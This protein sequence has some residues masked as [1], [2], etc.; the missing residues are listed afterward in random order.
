MAFF[1]HSHG[2]QINGGNFYNVAGSMNVQQQ[3]P[4]AAWG[5]QEYL[6]DLLGPGSAESSRAHG[7]G[8]IPHPS[9]HGVQRSILAAGSTRYEP[10]S[11]SR[12]RQITS[13]PH[14]P[15][16][17]QS[18]S[19]TTSH[20]RSLGSD[21]ATDRE[22]WVVRSPV[23]E[24]GQQQPTTTIYGGTFVS[25]NVRRESER[26]I[27]LLHGAV[28]LAAL[29][30]S[31][32]SFPQPR[33]H[34]ETRTKIMQDLHKWSLDTDPS[35]TILWL[36]GPAGAGKSA[37]MQTFSSELQAAGALGGSFFFKRD[38]ATRGNAKTLFS[39]IAYQ[40]ALSV[41]W[42]KGPIS[43][44]V[45]EDPS[46][47][48]RSMQMQLQKLICEPGR[49]CPHNEN[50]KPAI[51][52]IDGLDECEGQHIQQEILRALRNSTSQNHLP[53]RFIVASRPEAHICEVFKSTF[54]RDG[55]RS[56]N[57]EQ[58]FED[59][60][61]YLQDEFSRIHHEH[62]TMAAIPSPWPSPEIREEL[63]SKSSGYFIYAS[64]LIRF[65]DDKNYR[66]TERLAVIL[67]GTS[68]DSAFAALDQL[69]MTILLSVPRQAQLLPVLCAI[70]NFDLC[71]ECLERLLGLN[72][73]DA[74]LVLRG[75]NSLLQMSEEVNQFVPISSHH[76]SFLDFLNDPG[77]SRDFY[78]GKPCHRM[79]LARSLLELFTGEFREEMKDCCRNNMRSPLD[80]GSFV[81]SLPPCA[82]LLSP[83]RLMNPDYVF[84]PDWY[85]KN[86][87]TLL[88]WHGPKEIPDLH[89]DSERL[90][91]YY[92]SKFWM[93]P[94]YGPYTYLQSPGILRFL[95]W[96]RKIPGVPGDLLGLWEN[97][98]YM[99]F[100]VDII[101]L[102]KIKPRN[103]M[104]PVTAHHVVLQDPGTIRCLQIVL[105]V[106]NHR[107][108]MRLREICSILGF[109]WDKLK[110]TLCSLR[111]IVGRDFD[112]MC[113]L[114]HRMV[115]NSFFG[116]SYP[117]PALC[118]DLAQKLIHRIRTT[119]SPDKKIIL[120]SCPTVLQHLIRSSPFCPKLLYDVWTTWDDLCMDGEF[121]YNVSKWLEARQMN[122]HWQSKTILPKYLCHRSEIRRLFLAM[123]QA[124][125]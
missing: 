66:P 35:S 47:L 15:P 79:D 101:N 99:S 28:A 41:P 8:G 48:A 91:H 102:A 57:V 119:D 88:L 87:D 125:F 92:D 4:L 18:E 56:F 104:S 118:R 81:I 49:L 83:I 44:I 78:I 124:S 108:P 5:N 122:I 31:G 58:S 96:L 61:K 9:C 33:C 26:G 38:H 116:E 71:P 98:E 30:D 69:Y 73:G 39:T 62:Q 55:Y 82:E 112:K 110:T 1:D 24:P 95:I 80:F 63:V 23:R 42:L 117:W 77:R 12:R 29:H 93:V 34:P 21:A 7:G 85:L 25:S 53:Y 43:G 111:P 50:Q 74:R 114:V 2:M 40:L 89:E 36:H 52:V 64:T 13:G 76:A 65:I 51:I 32:E 10:Y 67:D 60:R 46:I 16:V 103:T 113:E 22:H 37:I 121:K 100:L 19:D 11:A 70:V 123:V 20:E 115:D 105:L 59:V 14:Q 17:S 86:L 54:Y 6:P 3:L 45:E 90:R 75:L 94:M 27:D 106:S 84:E 120:Y 68:S 109:T 107:F 72:N 97:Y